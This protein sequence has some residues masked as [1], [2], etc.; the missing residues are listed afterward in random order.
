[1]DAVRAFITRYP[2]A[3]YFALTFTISWGGVLLIIGGPAGMA[4]VKAQDNPLFPWAVLAMVAGPCVTGLL[5]TVLIDGTQ[6]LRA[7]LSRLM[8][9]RVEARW[10]AV[11]LLAAPLVATA[12]T[13]TLSVFSSEFLPAILLSND[14]AALLL[15]GV[16]VGVTAGIFEEI[17]WTG[18]AIPHLR[19]RYGVIATGLIVGVL[20][21]AWHILVTVWGIGDRA[22][23]VPLAVFVIVDGLAGLP[24]F[25]VLM[26]QVYDRTQSLFVGILM[27]IS[28]TATTL[29]L[30]PQT[31]GVSLLVYGLGFAGA[32]WLVIAAITQIDRR[33][34]S[35][36]PFHRTRFAGAFTRLVIAALALLAPPT[37]G[38]A[39][40]QNRPP[41]AA[42]FAA[43]WVGFADD[44]IVSEAM[45][46][47]GARWY[48]SPRIAIGP[49]VIYV[50]GTNHSH[51]VVTGNVTW[52]LFA[53]PNSRPGEVTPFLV[54]GVGVFRTRE[55]FFTGPFTS[56]E[57]AFT[58]GGGVRAPVSDRV[59]VGIDARIGWELHIRVNGVV[60][61]QLGG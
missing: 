48:L 38:I 41:L 19:Q 35:R 7:L 59:F 12:V 33:T 51:L 55:S 21:S 34:T 45:A 11:A 15:L 10:Y 13:L 8:A 47:G 2:V 58:A 53:P 31:K 36:R 9:W 3:S 18:F 28:V 44:G 17:G 24:A 40:A 57:G 20:W 1:M 25:R 23:S 4:G 49:E 26:V 22:G 30:T 46:G 42:E 5:L 56:N 16:A 54:G 60:G 27:H 52:D 50:D 61:V 14:T 39:A 32:M 37:V 43:G 29:I 6:G